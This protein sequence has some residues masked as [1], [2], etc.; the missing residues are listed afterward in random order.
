MPKTEIATASSA[1]STLYVAGPVAFAEAFV[2]FVFCHRVPGV[3]IQ[4]LVG[5]SG[6][7][8]IAF[9]RYTPLYITT[10]E[11]VE[12]TIIRNRDGLLTISREKKEKLTKATAETAGSGLRQFVAL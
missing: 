2:I 3:F 8:F 12:T 10:T 6:F 5:V 9:L 7:V 1:V 11:G 4:F